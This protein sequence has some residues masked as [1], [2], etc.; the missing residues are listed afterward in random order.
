MDSISIRLK[1]VVL[2]TLFIAANSL[3]IYL[4]FPSRLEEEALKASMEKGNS[5]AAMTA[6]VIAPALAHSEPETANEALESV[7]QNPEIVYLLAFDHSGKI[8]VAK[9]KVKADILKYRTIDDSQHAANIGDVYRTFATISHRGRNIGSV[10]IGLS[11]KQM[12]EEIRRTQRTIALTSLAIFVIGVFAVYGISL[13][14]TGPLRHM[15]QTAERIAKGDLKRRATVYSKDEVG[16]LAR[17]FNQ[18][19][20]RLES[21]RRELE[22]LN[23]SLETRVRDRT[24][25]LLQEI[26]ERRQAEEK[27]REQ[28]AL[29]NISQDAII[30][31]NFDDTI[32]FWNTGAEQLY[33]WT[34]Q[35]VT[36]NSF[37][38]LL[39][40][41][42]SP[43]NDRAMEILFQKGEWRGELRQ[44][45]RSG[46]EIIVESRWTTVRDAMGN[47]K[48]IL[49]VSTDI[50]ENKKLE[51]Q[52]LRAQRMESIGTLAGGIA[53]DLNNVLAPILMSVEVFRNRFKDEPSQRMLGSLEQSAKRGAEMVK[54]VLTFARGV[55]GER[56]TLQP[57]HLIKEMENIVKETF[58]PSIDIVIRSPR[59]IWIVSGDATQLHQVLLNL[60]V[61]ARDA[62]PNGGTLTL[63]LDNVEVD[64]TLK[65]LHEG[66]Q[67]GPHVVFTVCDTG[68]GIP[69]DIIHKIFDPFFTTKEVGV[70]TGLG[71]S[72]VLSIVRGH[73]GF[74]SVSSTPYK[75]T[76]F[77]VYLPATTA[78]TERTHVEQKRTMPHGHGELVMIV[79]D[80][81]AICQITKATLESFGYQVI[82]AGDGT[83]GVALHSRMQGQIRVILT[84][85]MMP[86]MNG[87]EMVRVIRGIDSD[88]KI[89][90]S[91]GLSSGYAALDEES[92]DAILPKPYAADTLLVKISELLNAEL[93]T[94]GDEEQSPG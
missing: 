35:E 61:N 93:E 56:V 4:Y 33:G 16:Y 6:F 17:S 88:V 40:N 46:T 20:D 11:L 75:G 63:S 89:I 90:A 5:I 64:E 19:V 45:T 34:A 12:R 60:S 31:R 74:V 32:L 26:A 52:F 78:E 54:Q 80:E 94:S 55:E 25:E 43:S 92:V 30:V 86:V 7:R 23:R 70:G 62:M 84:D 50:T 76:E 10:Y 3:F 51:K 65:S 29:L 49:V 47:P 82:T 13:M 67:T 1:L 36:G 2:F 91:S 79:D 42:A 39:H 38:D 8:F 18:M 37:T 28:A 87:P 41:P 85:M 59:D 81:A 68:T 83:E 15:V 48:S 21:A 66:A 69:L 44:I 77:K 58:P 9:D 14:A 53:H 73:G 71:L 27:I 22:N 72:T 24:K 57:R